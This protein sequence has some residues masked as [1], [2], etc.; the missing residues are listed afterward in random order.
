MIIMRFE[1]GKSLKGLTTLGIGGKADFFIE[2]KTEEDLRS[3]LVETAGKRMAWHIIGSGSNIVASD[4]GC[5][6][7]VVKIGINNFKKTGDKIYVGA[8]NNLL[9]FIKKVNKLGFGGMEKMA[10]IP[11]TVAGAIYGNAGAYGQEIKDSVSRVK[12]FDSEEFKWIKKGDCEFGYR[13]SVFKE[14]KDWIIVGAEF[15]LATG[16]PSVLNKISKDIIK[17]REKKYKPGL[18]CPGSFFKN[19]IIKDLKPIVRKK[20]LSKIDNS[21]IMYGKAPAGYLLEEVG[22]KGMSCG[23]I[24]V[25]KHHGNLIYNAGGGREKDIKNLARILKNL[26]RRRFGVKLEEEVQYLT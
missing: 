16:S 25:A 7:A 24:R 20:L 21:K 12:I 10:G 5:K 15:H 23:G 4:T 8:G 26:V 3:A 14:K 6:G 13:T 18:L 22:A 17:L 2:I 9:L 11:G 19:I 1:K